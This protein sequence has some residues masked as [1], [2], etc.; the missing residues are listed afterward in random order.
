MQSC[1][2]LARE[3]ARLHVAKPKPRH[4]CHLH[5]SAVFQV[6]LG[7]RLLTSA[8]RESLRSHLLHDRPGLVNIVCPSSLL[9]KGAKLGHD[10][11]QRDIAAWKRHTQAVKETKSALKFAVEL[12]QVCRQLGLRFVLARP[13]VQWAPGEP[14]WRELS[15]EV[16]V[17]RQTF[18]RPRQRKLDLVT[19]YPA[20][21]ERLGQI[22]A[23]DKDADNVLGDLGHHL[24]T[25]YGSLNGR[26]PRDLHTTSGEEVADEDQAHDEAYFTYAELTETEEGHTAALPPRHEV[27]AKKPAELPEPCRGDHPANHGID[28]DHLRDGGWKALDPDTW[29]HVDNEGGHMI[30]PTEE[31]F[32][33]EDF[34]WRS[35]WVYDQGRWSQ[36]ED[37][38]RWRDLRDRERA[39][40]GK[41][42]VATIFRRKADTKGGRN[43]RHFPGMQRVT[44]EKMVRRANEGLGHPERE[45]FLRI[46]HHSRAPEEV[47]Q[48]AKEL[49]C[50]VCEA[51]KLPDP[52]R[53]GAPPRE[54]VYVND[55][56]G[57]DT[58]HIRDH[59]NAAVP[60]INV[61]D[62]HSHFQLVVPMKGETAE[63]VRAAYRQWTRFFGPPRKLMIDLGPEYKAQFRKQAERDGAEVVPSPVEAPYQRGLT[64]RAGGIF[65]NILYK[66]MQDYRCQGEAEW[67]E[68]VDVACVTRNRLLMRAG[69][70]PIQGVLGYTLGYQEDFRPEASKITWRQIWSVWATY[71]PAEPWK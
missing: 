53:R 48:I 45:R 55:L 6:E 61:I 1:F 29:A 52:A 27:H 62:W 11:R 68:L 58:I 24:R 3:I 32:K 39:L 50:S 57:I 10:P 60:A 34:P 12:C 64:E 41:P 26:R 16:G 42:R 35:S 23:P 43:M 22:W 37:E 21:L 19:N 38:I 54:Q 5:V 66:A 8:A 33:P 9:P 59:R 15:K 17:T 44:L 70:S 46:L 69:Y 2:S 18:E 14:F 7:G 28:A 49:R 31:N 56:V 51:Y 4:D 47:I 63:H 40:P 30:A 36:I 65:K 67:R 71:K 25:A 20:L 13:W